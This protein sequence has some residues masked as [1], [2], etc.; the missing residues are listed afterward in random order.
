MDDTMTPPP[1]PPRR[2]DEP[3][4]ASTGEA[5]EGVGAHSIGIAAVQVKDA[6]VHSRHTRYASVRALISA[7]AQTDIASIGIL[8]SCVDIAVVEIS[9]TLILVASASV[10]RASRAF[11]V[12]G[13]SI[14]G[15]RETASRIEAEGVGV[16]IVRAIV[17]ASA[18]DRQDQACTHADM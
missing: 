16:A 12:I 2:V 1:K 11:N 4:Y 18:P 10:H 14:A 6:L 15:A 8:A 9:S 5:P 3:G 7:V 13:A 17:R